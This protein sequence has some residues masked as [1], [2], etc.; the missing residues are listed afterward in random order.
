MT[1]TAGPR[2]GGHT[3]QELRGALLFWSSFM[4]ILVVIQNNLHHCT[5]FRTFWSTFMTFWEI[6]GP[7]L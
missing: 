5:S 1:Y 6:F 3:S 2:S 7:R 4:T